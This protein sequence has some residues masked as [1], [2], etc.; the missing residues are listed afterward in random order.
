MTTGPTYTE[1]AAQVP[2]TVLLSGI[3]GSTAYGMAGEDS[4][5]DRLAVYAAPTVAFHGLDLPIE[6]AGTVVF[7]KPG[8]DFQVHEAR[9]FLT[10]AMKSNPTVTELLWLRDGLYE[11]RNHLGDAL[12]CLRPFLASADLVRNAYFGFA[13]QQLKKL[14]TTGQYTSKNRSSAVKHGRHVMRLLDQGLEFY[15][16]GHLTVRVT[17][18]R[19]DEY[20]SMGERLATD[21]PLGAQV[22]AEYEARFDAARPALPAAPDKHKAQAW[23]HEVRRFYWEN[24]A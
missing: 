19:R 4:D 10:L 3:V 22:L 9:K 23:L 8:P 6:K 12:I 16:T 11:H 21:P 5:I 14:A 24:A 1:L 7:A 2:G 18:E 15:T 20:F 13:S 17:Q